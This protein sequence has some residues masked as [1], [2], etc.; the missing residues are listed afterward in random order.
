MWV[1][2]STLFL[3]LLF[4]PSLSSTITPSS[5]L[6]FTF[7]TI[8]ATHFCPEFLS[9]TLNSP[10]ISKSSASGFW[11]TL[12]SAISSELKYDAIVS[13]HFLKPSWP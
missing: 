13:L 8:G 12:P 6:T 2:Y 4:L 10:R 11:N 5:L 3:L 7:C 1:T 9:V